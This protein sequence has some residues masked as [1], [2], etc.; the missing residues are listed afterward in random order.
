MIRF[1]LFQK[2]QLHVLHSVVIMQGCVR[3][4]LARRKVERQRKALSTNREYDP[5]LYTKRKSTKKI[6][7][8][9]ALPKL[10]KI[11]ETKS[12]KE[13]ISSNHVVPDSVSNNSKEAPKAT[14]NVSMPALSSTFSQPVSTTSSTTNIASPTVVQPRKFE[15]GQRVL[16]QMENIWSEGTLVQVKSVATNSGSRGEIPRRGIEVTYDVKLDNGL[17]ELGLVSQRVKHLADVT[18]QS[19]RSFRSNKVEIFQKKIYVH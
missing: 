19:E 13:P 12:A 9:A 5:T 1:V 2:V 14:T 7:T 8:D 10:H 4:K 16:A 6:V 3:K 17:I 18:I 15:V 11:S